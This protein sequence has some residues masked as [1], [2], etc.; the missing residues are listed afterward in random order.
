VLCCVISKA[1]NALVILVVEILERE[2]ISKVNVGWNHEGWKNVD[3]WIR[4]MIGREG[5]TRK[6][7]KD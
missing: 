1:Q 6:W 3:T 4:A 7:V 5:T 2:E